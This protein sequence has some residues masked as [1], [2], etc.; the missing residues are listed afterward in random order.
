MDCQSVTS[1]GGGEARDPLIHGDYLGSAPSSPG[2]ARGPHV[3]LS[4]RAIGDTC[5]ILALAGSAWARKSPLPLAVRGTCQLRKCADEGSRYLSRNIKRDCEQEGIC[6]APCMGSYWDQGHPTQQ[7]W[8]GAEQRILT[9]LQKPE[10]QVLSQLFSVPVP[11]T[12]GQGSGNTIPF[13]FLW[14]HP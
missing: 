6:S 10:C 4:G 9:T 13:L 11:R 2:R 12:H 1:P 3:P 5:G 14:L 8:T 7:L